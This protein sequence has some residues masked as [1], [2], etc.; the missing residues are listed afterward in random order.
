MVFI[1]TGGF[2]MAAGTRPEQITDVYRGGQG[3]GGI[4]NR[5]VFGATL[6]VILTM[7]SI[8]F[9]SHLPGQVTGAFIALCPADGSCL[10]ELFRQGLLLQAESDALLFRG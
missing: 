3:R 8:L 2:V 6:L 9:H 4:I 5:A 10:K 7:F 1:G